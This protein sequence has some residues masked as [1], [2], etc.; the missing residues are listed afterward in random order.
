MPLI[1]YVDN[2]VTGVYQGQNDQRLK[3]GN[4]SF[5]LDP[6]IIGA[7]QI[8]DS[9]VIEA[10]F[11]PS[12]SPMVR[13]KLSEPYTHIT[14]IQVGQF[15]INGIPLPVSLHNDA[16]PY[17]VNDQYSRYSHIP[18]SSWVDIC[19]FSSDGDPIN[20][21]YYPLWLYQNDGHF[22]HS[23]LFKYPQRYG[24]FTRYDGQPFS[25]GDNLCAYMR[26][27]VDLSFM[28]IPSYIP[29]YFENMDLSGLVPVF[30]FPDDLPGKPG[31][32]FP[33]GL[34]PYGIVNYLIGI[35]ELPPQSPVPGFSFYLTKNNRYYISYNTNF[36]RG[37]KSITNSINIVIFQNSDGKYVFSYLDYSPKELYEQDKQLGLNTFPNLY[38]LNQN[39]NS[40]IGHQFN[41]VE[42][43]FNFS[44]KFITY[45]CSIKRINNN[46]IEITLFEGFWWWPGR[47]WLN[48]QS[49]VL[50]MNGP[51]ATIQSDEQIFK[52]TV[53]DFFQTANINITWK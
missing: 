30:I 38:S 45:A 47:M 51:S 37:S 52:K 18:F 2:T 6:H 1:L 32:S 44:Y 13:Q 20:R 24:G 22:E 3:I 53:N 36:I 9:V 41:L 14:Y 46:Q 43:N 11:D 29:D 17:P 21:P 4:V 16:P 26:R 15:Y 28:D 50:A 25:N 8:K 34:D 23:K 5:N 31:V 33:Y 48:G 35:N 10:Y 12:S 49:G 7:T 39:I 40:T 27:H 42:N 19:E